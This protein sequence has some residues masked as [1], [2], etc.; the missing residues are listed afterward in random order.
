MEILGQSHNPSVIDN[1]LKKLY[2]GIHSVEFNN[3]KKIIVAMKSSNKE[4]V[5]LAQEVA[6]TDE[7]ED[8]LTKLSTSM[9]VTLQKMLIQCIK[10]CH[11]MSD[12]NRDNDYL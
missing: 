6:I 1:H 5:P 2:A 12:L 11:C 8:W 7:V 9:E 10:E 3:D 4:V